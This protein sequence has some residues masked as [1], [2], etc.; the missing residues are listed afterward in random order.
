M[1]GWVDGLSYLM[2]IGL[3]EDVH[4]FERENSL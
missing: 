4:F 3:K 2:V 1:D